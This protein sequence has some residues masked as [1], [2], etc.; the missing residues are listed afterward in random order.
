VSFDFAVML[1]IIEPL[2]IALVVLIGAS[3]GASLAVEN[4]FF[5]LGHLYRVIVAGT[6]F[7]LPLAMMRALG[8]SPTW[9]R[10]I[11]TALLWGV[12]AGGIWTGNR[13]TWRLWLRRHK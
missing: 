4:R 5:S 13:L 12:F 10:L 3:L 11:G 6:L 7:F 2:S 1:E 8:G 9:E